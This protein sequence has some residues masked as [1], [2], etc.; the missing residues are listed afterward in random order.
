MKNHCKCLAI[1]SAL[2]LLA[3]VPTAY[4]QQTANST[5]KFSLYEPDPARGGTFGMVAPTG[6]ANYVRLMR[7]A[8]DVQDNILRKGIREGRYTK[9]GLRDAVNSA[10]RALQ[11][12]DLQIRTAAA[13]AAQ[14]AA[15]AVAAKERQAAMAVAQQVT[16]DAAILALEGSVIQP[17]AAADA[18]SLRKAEAEEA[19]RFSMGPAYKPLTEQFGPGII[20]AL[21]QGKATARSNVGLTAEGNSSVLLNL[22]NRRFAGT[23]QEFFGY[24]CASLAAQKCEDFASKLNH[25]GIRFGGMVTKNGFVYDAGVTGIGVSN[26]KVDGLFRSAGAG[27]SWSADVDNRLGTTG[28]TIANAHTVTGSWQGNAVTAVKAG[29]FESWAGT[30]P[31]AF[32]AAPKSLTPQGYIATDKAQALY[33][34]STSVTVENLRNGGETTTA[35]GD[36]QLAVNVGRRAVTGSIGNFNQGNGGSRDT[37]AFLNAGEIKIAGTLDAATAKNITGTASWTPTSAKA[38]PARG[39][40]SGALAYSVQSG[41]GLNVA[42]RTFTTV[43]ASV[44]EGR[45][46][47]A[48]SLASPDFKLKGNWA[49]TYVAPPVPRQQK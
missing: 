4:A 28:S 8:F 42:E 1:A 38:A 10:N 47:G 21:Y 15:A 26:G 12:R 3:S 24:G 7:E 23:L 19:R 2:F 11:Q 31:P 14:L 34:G 25:S 45:G 36:V 20:K 48:W 41:V 16:R 5:G 13:E 43:P 27:G 35:Q 22:T 49:A 39:D 37:A 33:K 9:Q 17:P 18:V 40:F 30:T 29:G 32:S 6:D 44:S 46:N